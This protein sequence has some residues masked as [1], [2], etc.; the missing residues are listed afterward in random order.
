MYSTPLPSRTSSTI[1]TMVRLIPSNCGTTVTKSHGSPCYVTISTVSK[2]SHRCI[3][4][5][6]R[7]RSPVLSSITTFVSRKGIHDDSIVTVLY[8]D[9]GS[10]IVPLFL[11]CCHEFV[12][13]CYYQSPMAQGS[14]R[15]NVIQMQPLSGSKTKFRMEYPYEHKRSEGTTHRRNSGSQFVIDSDRTIVENVLRKGR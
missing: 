11:W 13:A 14:A 9:G 15:G 3:H 5:S 6:R 1:T 4:T 12:A 10:G 8:V 2:S 7:M